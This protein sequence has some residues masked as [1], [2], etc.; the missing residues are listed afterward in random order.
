[1]AKIKI[2]VVEDD[3]YYSDQLVEY[4]EEK[5]FI[6]TEVANNL[7]DALG[8]FYSQQPDLVI[9]DIYLNGKPDGIEFAK[10]LN[11]NENT[12]KPF[13]FLTGHTD[14]DTFR[15]AKLT[16]PFSYL[17]KPFNPVELQYTIELAIEKFA[18]DAGVFSA[19][20][21]GGVVIESAL[22]MKKGNTLVKVMLSQVDYVEVAGKHSK[23]EADGST[24]LISWPLKKIIQKLGAYQFIQIHRNFVVNLHAIA[25]VDLIDQQV[26]LK[27]GKPIPFSRNFRDNLIGSLDIMK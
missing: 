23:I 4:L 19:E 7:K 14:Q 2:L 9:V 26:M 24:Y 21:P 27:N 22:F 10:T 3:P 8:Y 6:V 25:K 16:S 11:E 15:D 5:D 18:G 20:S 1:M 13:I 17:I 12:R